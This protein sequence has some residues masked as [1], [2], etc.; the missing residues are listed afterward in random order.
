VI[1][2]ARREEA[3]HRVVKAETGNPFT[4]VVLWKKILPRSFRLC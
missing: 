2:S 3:F 4:G 1:P